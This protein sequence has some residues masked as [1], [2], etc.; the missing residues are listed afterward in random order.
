MG[1]ADQGRQTKDWFIRRG[2]I[3]RSSL[4][5]D[6]PYHSKRETFI[7]ATRTLDGKPKQLKKL[8][9][10]CFAPAAAI[11]NLGSLAADAANL[12]HLAI[13]ATLAK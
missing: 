8:S 6:G 7:N 12:I 2:E 3:L 11:F 9:S 4:A 10:R 5:R 13:S 1:D